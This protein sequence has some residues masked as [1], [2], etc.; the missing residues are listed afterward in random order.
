MLLNIIKLNIDT[1]LNNIVIWIYSFGN[2]ITNHS[3]KITQH[4]AKIAIKDISKIPL[5]KLNGLD[6]LINSIN[7]V[8]TV[9]ITHI[10]EYTLNGNS[11]KLLIINT[12]IIFTITVS[13]VGMDLLITFPINL[14]FTRDLFGSNASM[15]DGIPI[16]T[17]AIRLN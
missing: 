5:N 6:I 2:T 4:P 14:P 12:I 15:N 16:H 8:N 3:V 11:T 13:A 1:V 9:K 17:N 7:P 10:V